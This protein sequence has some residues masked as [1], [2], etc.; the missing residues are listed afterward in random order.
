[1][2]SITGRVGWAQKTRRTGEEFPDDGKGRKRQKRK[3]DESVGETRVDI[4]EQ[5]KAKEERMD[6]DKKN[7]HGSRGSSQGVPHRIDLLI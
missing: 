3:E 7:R 4:G 1:M 6:P 2:S 5:G